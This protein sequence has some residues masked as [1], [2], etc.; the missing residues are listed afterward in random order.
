MRDLWLFLIGMVAGGFTTAGVLWG[1][2]IWT[3]CKNPVDT[4]SDW[5]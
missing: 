1:L 3:L 5:E 2:V 4:S